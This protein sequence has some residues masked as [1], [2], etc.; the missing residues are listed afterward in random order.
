MILA[1]GSMVAIV[2]LLC[3]RSQSDT[4]I[5][6]NFPLVTTQN[7]SQANVGAYGWS[8]SRVQI[9]RYLNVSLSAC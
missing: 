3:T 4:V 6:V 2:K 9:P 1:V 7:V 5:H 8:L